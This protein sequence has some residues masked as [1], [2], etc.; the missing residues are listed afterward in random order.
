[1]DTFEF[2]NPVRLVFGQ[3]T[4]DQIGER[5][6]EFGS[7]ALL[8]TGQASARKSGLLDRALDSLGEAGA[9]VTVFDRIM[10]NPT[11]EIVLEGAE[12]ARSEGVDVVVAVG[13][14]SP[15][16]AAKAIAVAATHEE[17]LWEFLRPEDRREATE[18]TLPIICATT[19][20]GTSSELTPFA[21]IT[22]T[23]QKMKVG[24]GSENHYPKVAIVDPAATLT[25]PESVTANTGADV[26]A[27]SMEG[28]F[29]TEANAVTDLFAEKAIGIV[30]RWLPKAVGNCENM[31]AREMMSLANVYA[32][33]VLSNCGASVMHALEH[34]I[35]A[36]HP[37]VAHG[38]GLAVMFE[39]YARH[40]WDRDPLK[41]GKI[42]HLLGRGVAGAPPEQSAQYAADGLQ[43]LLD[44]VGLNIGLKDLGV[45][46]EEIPTLVDDA[47]HYMGGA[48][49]KTPSDLTRDDLIKLMED[50]FEAK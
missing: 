41:F 49:K 10:P 14:G 30:G 27:H 8:V 19:T 48:V 39:S 22:V 6:R 13:G 20:S 44:S 17:P 25:C 31:Q 4:F 43:R 2:F 24:I 28:Y 33:Y 3:G 7:R 29:S 40:Y 47:L 45:E 38:A 18:A 46:R 36:H 16:D 15:M 35:S 9:D 12:V 50:S 5:S 26:L 11:D 23:E 21:V 1:M 32:G 34:P 42:A 37:E